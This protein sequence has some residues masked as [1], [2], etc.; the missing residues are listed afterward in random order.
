MTNKL[1]KVQWTNRFNNQT[2]EQTY[3]F[4]NARNKRNK[5]IQQSNIKRAARN[6]CVGKWVGGLVRDFLQVRRAQLRDGYSS[7][8]PKRVI[9]SRTPE[10]MWAQWALGVQAPMAP[11]GSSGINALCKYMEALKPLKI[12]EC[13]NTLRTNMQQ[14]NKHYNSSQ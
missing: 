13:C 14:T 7:R 12:H 5:K 8:R 10:C 3:K 4:K 9:W 6:L 1:T 11:Q 2:N